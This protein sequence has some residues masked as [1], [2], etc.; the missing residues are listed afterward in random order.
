MKRNM[1]D[2]IHTSN[3]YSKFEDKF[4]G[5]RLLIKL[6]QEKYLPYIH[7]LKK[8]F[9]IVHALDLGCGR[10]EW[11]EILREAD[12]VA[13][14]IDLNDDMLNICKS[15]GYEVLKLDAV[16]ALRYFPDNSIQ[17]LTGFHIAEHLPFLTLI[18]LVRESHRVLSPG[19]VLILETPNSENLHV[20]TDTFYLDPFHTNPIPSELLSFL[21]GY[22]GFNLTDVIRLNA[23]IDFNSS[24][25]TSINDVLKGVSRDYAAIGQKIDYEIS[26]EFY[27]TNIESDKGISLDR[28]IQSYDNGIIEFNVKIDNLILL[29]H[30]LQFR[31][32]RIERPF[33]VIY[34]FLLNAKLALKK[35]FSRGSH[36]NNN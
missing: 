29:T 34:I 10:G 16:S 24:T 19:G 22:S 5:S 3:F 20:S 18:E 23:D 32:H 30:E 11:L 25:R 1:N 21:L 26:K 31:I 15:M 35:L 9:P 17:L 7:L 28:L 12:I 6:R 13:K 14:G 8:V 27:I 2:S 33:K 4:R 36:S